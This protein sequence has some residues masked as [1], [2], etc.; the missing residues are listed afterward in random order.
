MQCTHYTYPPGRPND[1][2]AA[3]HNR[4]QRAATYHLLTP[5]GKRCPGSVLCQEH[6]QAVV[7][8]YAT[9]LAEQWFLQAIDPQLPTPAETA[10]G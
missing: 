7:D 2:V 1:H 9:K 5:D 4:C 10:T 6:G 8:E 3:S